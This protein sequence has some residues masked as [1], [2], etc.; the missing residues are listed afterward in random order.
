MTL[1]GTWVNHPAGTLVLTWTTGEAP[2]RHR[3]KPH[4]PGMD[5]LQG[6]AAEDGS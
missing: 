4:A 2:V 6:P 1:T 3:Q 5:P